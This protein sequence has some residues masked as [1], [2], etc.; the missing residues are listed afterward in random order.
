MSPSQQQVDVL[1][2][3]HMWPKK[4]KVKVGHLNSVFYYSAEQSRFTR[5]RAN[6]R[7]VAK[8]CML[9]IVCD[10]AGSV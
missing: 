1:V 2:F 9:I 3:P 7:A 6:T 4:V 10:T 5:W 8:L